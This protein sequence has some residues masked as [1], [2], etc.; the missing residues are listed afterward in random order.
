MAETNLPLTLRCA[1]CGV[2]SRDDSRGWK[3]YLTSDEPP[4]LA[5]YCP[6]CVAREFGSEKG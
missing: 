6:Q 3:T 5:T 1:E 4:E 2:E